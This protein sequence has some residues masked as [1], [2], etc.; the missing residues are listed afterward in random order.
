MRAMLRS[1]DQNQDWW[2]LCGLASTVEDWVMAQQGSELQDLYIRIATA[3]HQPQTAI[4]VLCRVPEKSAR[5]QKC[6]VQGAP[7]VLRAPEDNRSRRRARKT[8]WLYIRGAGLILEKSLLCPYRTS[9][10][11]LC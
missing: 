11:G 6:C 1:K 5:N 2:D 3:A 8:E 7:L 4:S 10:S 9:A